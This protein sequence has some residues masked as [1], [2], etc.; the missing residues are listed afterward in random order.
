MFDH[1]D[2]DTD[3]QQEIDDVLTPKRCK[4]CVSIEGC[5]PRGICML[6]GCLSL[7]IRKKCTDLSVPIEAADHYLR[8][9]THNCPKWS[10][11]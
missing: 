8:A 2:F 11:K 1:E 9:E 4:T 3:L 7:D 5:T 6:M 10:K